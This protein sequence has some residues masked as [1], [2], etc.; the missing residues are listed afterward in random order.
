MTWKIF[1]TKFTQARNIHE[2][3]KGNST[4]LFTFFPKV[5]HT[6]KLNIPDGTLWSVSAIVSVVV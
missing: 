4:N 6:S 3:F 1:F 5:I 2:A